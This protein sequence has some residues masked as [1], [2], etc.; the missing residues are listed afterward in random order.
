MESVD[1]RSMYPEPPFFYKLF[2][3][4]NKDSRLYQELHEPPKIPSKRIVFNRPETDDI[5]TEAKE[6]EGITLESPSDSLISDLQ[7]L[8][9]SI[10][11]K[12]IEFLQILRQ[13]ESYIYQFESKTDEN[14]GNTLINDNDTAV[15]MDP[16][17]STQS[18]SQSQ[19][20]SQTQSQSE[21]ISGRPNLDFRLES[22]DVI[23]DDGCNIKLDDIDKT[24]LDNYITHLR[25]NT[26]IQNIMTTKTNLQAI[27]E[28]KTSELRS[29]F[30]EMRNILNRMRAHQARQ[31]VIESLKMQ[32]E[33]KEK[34]CKKLE[35]YINYTNK[36]LNKDCGKIINKQLQKYQNEYEQSPK[37]QN[38]LQKKREKEEIQEKEYKSQ[39][40]QQ[41]D[42]IFLADGS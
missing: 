10:L 40:K 14:D 39:L 37:I 9:H 27:I 12:Y 26:N 33:Y 41:L 22:N 3:E 29:K 7:G 28:T 34:Q 6:D 16:I 42:N 36:L 19:T 1:N 31:T 18:Q 15:N 4:S 8:N 21:I 32:L 30:I 23:E 11:S 38:S 35:N 5:V 25:F 20:Q 24:L 13:P 17:G 2:D